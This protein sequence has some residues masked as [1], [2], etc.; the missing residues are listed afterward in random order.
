MILVLRAAPCLALAARHACVLCGT[1]QRARPML[2]SLQFITKEIPHGT[3]EVREARRVPRRRPNVA[4]PPT[5]AEAPLPDRQAGGTD[6]AQQRR[7]SYGLPPIRRWQTLI[8]SVCARTMRAIADYLL[9]RRTK[10]RPREVL[11]RRI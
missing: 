6:R 10:P 7:A 11:L 2:A 5:R 8:E 3:A 1:G 9:G 4:T